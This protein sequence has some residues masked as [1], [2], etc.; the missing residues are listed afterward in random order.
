MFYIN[1]TKYVEQE[2]EIQ[3]NSEF[4]FSSP[5]SSLLGN[6]HSSLSPEFSSF[7]VSKKVLRSRH[8]KKMFSKCDYEDL[9][10]WKTVQRKHLEL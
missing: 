1:S 8:Q 2:E 3:I 10:T 4:S 7:Y 9:E 5:V 6:T